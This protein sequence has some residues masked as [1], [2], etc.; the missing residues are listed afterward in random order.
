MKRIVVLGSTGSAGQQTLDVVRA[1]PDQLQVIGL[2]AKTN[3]ELLSQQVGEFGPKYLYFSQEALLEPPPL[4]AR[5]A[6]VS[7]EEMAALPEA[8]LVVSA[9]A[10]ALASL[11]G[12]LAALKAG[13]RLVLAHT[14]VMVMA[15]GLLMQAAREHGASI[16][17]AEGAPSAIWQ[18]MRGEPGE[19]RRVI[20]TTT[21]GPS[22]AHGPEMAQAAGR[23]ATTRSAQRLG[24]KARVDTMTLM[25][26]GMQAIESYYLFGIPYDRM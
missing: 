23:D 12:T 21:E 25:N 6:W 3:H 5:P 16:L 2:A 4:L 9:T 8:D 26:V 17:P 22:V 1:F 18:C 13:K 24:K 20:L 14:E 19:A 11:P 15:G 10:S 7:M